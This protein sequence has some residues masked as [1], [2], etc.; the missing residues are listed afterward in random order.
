MDY[1][2]EKGKEILFEL[3]V[4]FFEPRDLWLDNIFLSKAYD[5]AVSKACMYFKP[6]CLLGPFIQTLAAPTSR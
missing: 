4:C 1:L 3:L 6:D 2:S 5:R